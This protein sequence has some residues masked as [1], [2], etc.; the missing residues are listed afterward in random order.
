MD[1]GG[2]WERVKR[3]RVARLATI[4]P[5]GRPDLVPVTFA[6]D[7]D[8][9][10]AR[11]VIAVDH[12]PKTTRRLQRLAN[13]TDQPD[14][15]LLIDHYDDDW[16]TLWWIR[17]DGRARVEPADD[18]GALI[19]KYAPYQTIR[20]AGPVIEIEITDWQWWSAADGAGR[21]RATRRTES[22]PSSPLRPEDP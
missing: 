13:V 7:G 18:V 9:S 20:P 6:L 2:A 11:I 8:T 12:K 15:S 17:L 4:G 19:A 3:A 22:I 5:D 21:A 14:V 16:T 1:L 10:R